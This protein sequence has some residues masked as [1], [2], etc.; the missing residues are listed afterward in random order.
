MSLVLSDRLWN[1][2]SRVPKLLE[3]LSCI[4]RKLRFVVV[5][6]AILALP[7]KL[8][9]KSVINLNGVSCD[10]MTID[11]DAR[12][13]RVVSI[14]DSSLNVLV[15][16]PSL[17]VIKDWVVTVDLDHSLRLD[18]YEVRASNSCMEFPSVSTNI[19]KFWRVLTGLE[20][21]WCY[22]GALSTNDARLGGGAHKSCESKT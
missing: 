18:L 8:V 10:I 17:D 22:S 14:F 12:P 6:S 3:V 4:K 15:S 9:A 5:K 20:D 11:S 1:F 19:G 13:Y 21:Q 16:S 2:V 7:L